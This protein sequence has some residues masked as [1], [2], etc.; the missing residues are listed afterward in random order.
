MPQNLAQV[1]DP[2]KTE[3]AKNQLIDILNNRPPIV[4]Y[5][6]DMS[7]SRYSVGEAAELVA[8]QDREEEITKSKNANKQLHIDEC[9]AYL[10][11]IKESVREGNQLQNIILNEPMT[12][13]CGCLG[14]D[15]SKGHTLCPC[16]MTNTIYRY[17]YHIYRHFQQLGI[18]NEDQP[19]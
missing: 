15:R 8:L 18:K 2:T 12:G 3:E 17:K 5:P 11:E 13:F 4:K 6:I 10:S 9:I 14:P 16:A 7:F 1:F 19:T